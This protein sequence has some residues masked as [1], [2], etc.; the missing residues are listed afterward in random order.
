MLFRSDGCNY[1]VDSIEVTIAGNYPP[2]DLGPEEDVICV[3]D[4]YFISLDPT[5]STYVWQNGSTE[6]QYT[7]TAPGLYSVTLDDGCLSTTDDIFISFLDPPSNFTLG[8]DDFICPGEVIEYSFDPNLG[9]FLWQDNSTLPD[10]TISD[11]GTY[12][13][14]ISN[15][16]GSLSDEIEITPLEPPVVEIGPDT[17]TIC[18][19]SVIHLEIEPQSGDIL[20][21][22]GSTSTDYLI[23]EPGLYSVTITNTCGI[24]TDT[25]EVISISSPS[26][27]HI[28]LMTS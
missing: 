6:P 21:Q 10:Y 28:L 4:S 8:P 9:Q 27:P 7:I 25:M 19:G 15:M 16:C 13:L 12:Q 26:D 22:D 3:G 23:D 2:V 24:A 18:N 17:M 14:V 20:W 5:L 1:A 11:E